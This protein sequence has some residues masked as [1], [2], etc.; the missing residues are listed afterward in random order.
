MKADNVAWDT[1]GPDYFQCNN[2][3]TVCTCQLTSCTVAAG[4]NGMD[5]IE[6]STN[7]GG[8][9]TTNNTLSTISCN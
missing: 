7:L 2:T 5:A 6:D 3:F 4:A 8:I 1:A 9:S